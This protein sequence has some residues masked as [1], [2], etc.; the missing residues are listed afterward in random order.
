MIFASPPPNAGN[1]TTELLDDK[2]LEGSPALAENSR[3]ARWEFGGHIWHINV[4]L[5]REDSIWLSIAIA[6]CET[7]SDVELR[8]LRY[9]PTPEE[10]VREALC[11]LREAVIAFEDRLK[12]QEQG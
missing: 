4:S 3:T 2:G 7:A 12:P 5:V 8:G 11:T 10:A 9:G 6:Y 1:R